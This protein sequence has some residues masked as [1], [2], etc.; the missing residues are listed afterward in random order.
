MSWY[1]ATVTANAADL[2]VTVATV[3]ERCGI[4]TAH[5]DAILQ[6][7]IQEVIAVVEQTCNLSV[8]PKTLVAQ[9]DSWADLERLPDG[10]VKPGSK[11]IITYT[12]PDGGEIVLDPALYRLKS[13]GLTL[14]LVPIR[15]WPQAHRGAPVTVTYEVGFVE[16]PF[17]LRLGIIMRVAEIYGKP[18]SSAAD[19]VTDFDRLLVNWRRG[20]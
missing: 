15:S 7:M 10:P 17:D 4:D 8:T 18:E 6:M 14:G 16:L 20:A 11:P 19:V 5:D 13:D 3:K 12:S 2:P 9:C 1:A